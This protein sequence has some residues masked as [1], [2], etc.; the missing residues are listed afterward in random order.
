MIETTYD[1]L[2]AKVVTHAADR[3]TALAELEHALGQTSVLGVTTTTGFLRELLRSE[4]VRAGRLDTGLI[5]RLQPLGGG[6]ETDHV[7]LAAALI[8]L[9]LKNERSGDDP[10]ARVDGWRLGGR[11]A[12]SWWRLSVGG[13]E[14]IELEL[15]DVA[16][17]DQQRTSPN[18]FALTIAGERGEWQYATDGDLIWIGAGGWAWAVRR[19]MAS[20][21]QDAQSD[22][23]LRAPMP[24]QVLLVPARVGDRVRTGD[25]V[26]VLESMKMELVLAAPVDG[27]VAELSVGVGDRVAVDQPL[28]RVE[29][30]E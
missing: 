18:S 7:A 27:L 29:S 19:A 17:H 24:G 21:A 20:A 26:V 14:P 5:G 1:S 11:R 12:S 8:S 25:P 2:L 15:K 13:S 16:Q 6:P 9:A 30:G 4:D 10:F 28:A 23:D 22:G 3:A